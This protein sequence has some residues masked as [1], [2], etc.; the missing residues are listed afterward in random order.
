[1]II[2][3]P[4]ALEATGDVRPATPRP[5]QPYDLSGP[6]SMVWRPVTDS[7]ARDTRLWLLALEGLISNCSGFRFTYFI[8]MDHFHG[9]LQPFQLIRTYP[10]FTDVGHKSLHKRNFGYFLSPR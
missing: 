2:A 7:R 10:D 3:E 8:H 4:P 6:E 5:L 1:V 9:S